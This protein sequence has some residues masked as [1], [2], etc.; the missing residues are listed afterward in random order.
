MSIEEKKE[1]AL[2]SY[3]KTF[4]ILSA[5]KKANLSDEEIKLLSSDPEFQARMDYF[6]ILEQERIVTALKTLSES[7]NEVVK[8]KSVL[9]LGKILYPQKFISA[10][11]D[12]PQKI[13]V[14]INS[15]IA[16]EVH[17]DDDHAAGVLRILSECGAIPSGHKTFTDTEIN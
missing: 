9:E 7:E 4:D 8:L 6:L 12:K 5:Y 3:S 13:E 1:I 2:A 15:K 17:Q 10:F 16:I 14:D 11:E